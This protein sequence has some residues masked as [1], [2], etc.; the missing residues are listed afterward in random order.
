MSFNRDNFAACPSAKKA[1]VPFF[2]LEELLNRGFYIDSMQNRELGE[3]TQTA[4]HH[5]ELLVDRIRKLNGAQLS[6]GANPHWIDRRHYDKA[7]AESPVDY[8]VHDRLPS[9]TIDDVLYRFDIIQTSDG[10]ALR[11]VQDELGTIKERKKKYFERYEG[12]VAEDQ[13]KEMTDLLCELLAN[14]RKD[15][16]SDI[17]SALDKAT[18]PEKESAPELRSGALDL[19][20]MAEKKELKIPSFYDS[21]IFMGM[22]SQ[23][24]VCR[25]HPQLGLLIML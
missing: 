4:V 10:V 3:V 7:M 14:L 11:V 5:L 9:F 18:A 16:Q 12:L 20:R 24:C 17:F 2:N 25:L 8:I 23:R 15:L 21:I 13:Q 1:T 22:L 19:G 6:R